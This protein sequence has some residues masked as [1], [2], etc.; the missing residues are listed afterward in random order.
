M[1]DFE[2]NDINWTT[3]VKKKRTVMNSFK[4]LGLQKMTKCAG[5][6]AFLMGPEASHYLNKGLKFYGVKYHSIMGESRTVPVA[7]QPN[8]IHYVAVGNQYGDF[9]M[10][11]DPTEK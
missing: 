5:L 2:E 8:M 3:A 1:A 11:Y 7:K 10:F 4:A 9:A 6:A